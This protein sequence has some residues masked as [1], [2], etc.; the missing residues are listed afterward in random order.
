MTPTANKRLTDEGWSE[1]EARSEGEFGLRRLIN[2]RVVC[3]TGPM[4]KPK[5]EKRRERY[6]YDERDVTG[7]AP[8]FSA[9]LLVPVSVGSSDL[10]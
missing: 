6:G 4:K 8:A 1:K 9:F 2:G 5:H 3:R 10:F 7:R